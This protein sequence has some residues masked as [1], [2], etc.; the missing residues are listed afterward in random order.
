MSDY[1]RQSRDKV[2][3]LLGSPFDDCLYA[4]IN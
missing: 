4:L 2:G 1:A 3:P